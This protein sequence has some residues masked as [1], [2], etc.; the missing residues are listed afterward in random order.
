MS[1]Y[2]LITPE[3]IKAT[4]ASGVDLSFDDG[5][6]FSDTMFESAIKQS[7]ALIE[8]D[9]GIVLDPYLVKGERHDARLQDKNAFWPFKLDMQ[10]ISKVEQID[11]TLGTYQPVNVPK[12]WATIVSAEHGQFHLVPTSSTV[13]SFF[14]RGGV[15]LLFGD[16]FSPYTYVPGYFSIKYR[17]GFQYEENEVTIPE[18][19]TSF[20][21]LFDEEMALR[22][23]I[24]SLEIID[25]NGADGVKVSGVSKEGFTLK[26]KT[27]SVGGDL[28]IKYYATTVDPLIFRAV[29]LLAAMLP[30]NISGDLIA[31]AGIGQVRLGIDGLTQEIHTTASATN[32]GYGARIT[33]FYKE[34]KHVMPSLRA[35]YKTVNFGTY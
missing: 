5:T 4:Y 24:H 33:M 20:E 8:A 35:K 34:L 9:L 22:P 23:N 13:G 6:P 30:L 17:A 2:D 31:G 19:S 3:Y 1:I 11:I 12:D 16:V 7:V 15:P 28:V 21:V 14:F 32:A 25:A 27:P 29:S 26:I 10:P 18:G